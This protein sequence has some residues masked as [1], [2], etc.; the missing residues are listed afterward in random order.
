MPVETGSAGA[1]LDASPVKRRAPLLR[2]LEWIATGILV[3]GILLAGFIVYGLLD[4]RWYKVVAVAGG[5][6]RPAIEPGDLIVLTR[7]PET[8]REGMILT[9]QINGQVV[10]HRVVDF[11]QDGS[12][13]TKGDANDARDDFRGLDVRVVGEV[14]LRIPWL[15]NLIGGG[16]LAG[17]ATGAFFTA[18]ETIPVTVATAEEFLVEEDLPGESP[19]PEATSEASST[20]A[21]EPSP[22]PTPEP[23]PAP[24]GSTSPA[25][26][27]SSA[28]APEAQAGRRSFATSLG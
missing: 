5:S 27:A 24:E 8:I 6:M 12:F 14:R 10:T 3:A 21:A 23:E 15:G 7:P 20:Q 1:A 11:R 28:P 25:P 17:P 9:M 4:N 13:V 2:L 26:E 19:G 16:R 18:R 22:T